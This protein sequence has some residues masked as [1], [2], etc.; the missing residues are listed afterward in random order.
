MLSAQCGGMP[1][2]IANVSDFFA[3]ELK[4]LYDAETLLVDAL[5]VLAREATDPEVRAAFEEHREQTRVQLER[6]E[7]VFDIFG[8]EPNRGEGCAGVRG[9]L[10]EKKSLDR[11]QPS[12][13]VL[14]LAN[15][16]AAAKAERY[17]ISAY[18]SLIQLAS[19]MDLDDVAELLEASLEEEEA[20]LERVLDFA[21]SFEVE[22]LARPRRDVTR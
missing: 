10:E 1:K 15:L 11:H 20:A 13:P 21:D 4:D 2:A 5:G 19:M 22:E 14:Q 9:L 8:Q 7:E 16:S 6:L 18:E 3:H 12:A 17:E